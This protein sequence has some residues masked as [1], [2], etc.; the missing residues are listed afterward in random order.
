MKQF[1]LYPHQIN[2]VEYHLAAKYSLNGSEMGVGKTIIALETIKKSGLK[3]LVV[4]PAFL[5]ETWRR[6]ADKFRVPITYLPYSTIHKA[7]EKDLRQFGCWIADECHYLKNPSAQRTRAFYA[8]LKG[9]KPEYFLGMSGTLVKNKVPDL[10]VPL[11]ICSQSSGTN[12]LRLE[13]ELQK[14]RAFSYHFCNVETLM[15][16]GVRVDKFSGVREANLPELKQLLVGKYIAVKLAEVAHIPELHRKEF[17]VK[18]VP[19]PG[20]EEEWANYLAGSRSDPTSKAF[21]AFTKAEE[22]AQYA[23]ELLEEGES[24]VVFSDHI[25]SAKV[26]AYE[27]GAVCITGAMAAADRADMVQDFQDGRT[28]V[29]VATIGSLSVGVTLTAARHVI[30][31]D[32]SWCHSDNVQAEARIRRIGQERVC[33]SH[34][35]IGSVT[36][37]KIT[38]VLLTK[39]V[40][41]E[42]V[43]Q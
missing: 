8:L 11:A 17:F 24:I 7:K 34:Y 14:Y 35:A 6:E 41:A 9:I 29:I 23:K 40:T 16:R 31:N 39:A 3:G 2:A 25:K 1:T 38:K 33:I 18:A 30:F 4:G 13:G 42:R 10:W 36:D 27:L 37:E 43:L 21:S 26:L 32:M 20:L 19:V 22:T 28:K 5:A 15:I 12:G